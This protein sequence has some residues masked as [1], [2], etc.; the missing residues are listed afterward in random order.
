MPA[1]ELSTG[2][3]EAF[4]PCWRAEH[5][6]GFRCRA[7]AYTVHRL[8]LPAATLINTKPADGKGGSSSPLTEAL[9]LTATPGQSIKENRRKTYELRDYRSRQDRSGSC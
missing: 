2:S 1:C 9:R 8:L 5:A 7:S 4:D 3:E 6:G